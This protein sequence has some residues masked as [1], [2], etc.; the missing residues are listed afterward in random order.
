MNT[1]YVVGTLCL[2]PP[3]ARV[4]ACLPLVSSHSKAVDQ[5][6]CLWSLKLCCDFPHLA[7]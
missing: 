3:P 6:S 1:Q 4:I 2:A 5:C 7:N